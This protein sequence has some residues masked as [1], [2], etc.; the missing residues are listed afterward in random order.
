MAGNPVC[1]HYRHHHR[2][3][4]V[5]HPPAEFEALSGLFFGFTSR[6]Y[7]AG[8]DQ[9]KR[10]RDDVTGILYSG[11]YESPSGCFRGNRHHE[12]RTGKIT[13]DDYNGLYSTNPK[14]SIV[15]MLALFS[16]AGILRLP[17]FSVN[18]SSLPAAAEQGFYVLVF[19]ALLN[20]IISLYYYLLVVKAMFINKTEEAIAPV[21]SDIYTRLSLIVC[22]AGI[23][24]LGLLSTVYDTSVCSASA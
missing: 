9:R 11:V 14:L 10:Y 15:M 3:Q 12:N 8:S 20:T 21:R 4:P 1:N 17:V 5:C 16:L 2:S 24:I 22:T 13:I 18:F 23:L 6:I 19:I 7:Y